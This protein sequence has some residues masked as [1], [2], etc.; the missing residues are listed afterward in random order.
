MKYRIHNTILA[1]IVILATSGCHHQ[2]HG[3]GKVQ[4]IQQMTQ[5]VDSILRDDTCSTN[6]TRLSSVKPTSK[7][8]GPI[9][10]SKRISAKVSDTIVTNNVALI[11]DSGAVKR[12]VE[13]SIVATT[14]EHSGDIP[15]YM[16][17][18]TAD[19]A[20]Y[21]MLPDGQKFD[22]DITIAMRYDSTALPFG[23]TPDD[24]YT[25]FY[26]EQAHMW[27]Q[28]ARDSVDV[29]N[30]IVYSRTNHFTDYINGVLKVPENSDAMAYTP[31]TIKDLKA[32]DPMEGISFIAP[33]EAN[34]QG[35]ANLTYPLAIPAGRHGMQPQLSICYNSA[36]GSGILGMGWSLPIS[37]ISVE[38]R[39]GVPLFDQSYETETYLL[40][41]TTL[42]T[43]YIDDDNYFRLNKPVYHR[44]LENR[45]NADT[46]RFYPRVEGAFRKIERI[47]RTPKSYYWIVTDK[48]G[49]R[50]FYGCT[51][52]SRLRDHKNNI[53]KWML[54]K[55]VDT[56]GN[57]VTYTYVTKTL[58]I[59]SQPLAKQICID[60]IRY[61]GV[62]GG[63]DHGQYIIRF[64]YFD[65]DEKSTS[66]RYGL[67]ETDN[68]VLDRIEVMYRDSIVR[69]Y[70]FG[71]KKG[72]FGKT[73][74]GKIFEGF[75]DEARNQQYI[76][77]DS[78]I[79][80]VPNNPN[81]N[82]K[83]PSTIHDAS[84]YD[85]YYRVCKDSVAYYPIF[86]TFD[87]YGLDGNDLFDEPIVFDATG[88]DGN[89]IDVLGHSLTESGN[90]GVS[91]SYGFNI[92]GS[93]NFGTDYLPW[94]KTISA[95]GHYS[96][97]KDYS[98]GFM[99]L[100]DIDGDGYPDKL[101]RNLTGR[102]KC[103]LQVPGQNRFDTVRYISGVKKFQKTTSSTHNWGIEASAFP[104]IGAGANWSYGMSNTSIYVSD[105]NGDGLID[106]ID[107][108]SVYINKGNLLFEDV[109][110]S[111]VVYIGGTC[112]N[113]TYDV[114]GEV[115]TTI[116]D[117][118]YYTVERTICEQKTD[119]VAVYDTVY[120]ADGTYDVIYD[121]KELRYSRDT[122]WS[123][124]DTFY[125]NYPRRYEP[126]IDLVR[127][128]KAPYSGTVR[129]SGNA[130]L[131][132]TLATFRAMTR[133]NDG[134]RLSIQKASETFFSNPVLL[135]PGMDTSVS[136]TVQVVAGDT[137][138]FRIDAFDKRLYDEVVWNPHIKYT[139]VTLPNNVNVTNFNVV[140]ANGD[141]VYVFDY[142]ADFMLDGIIPVSLGDTT[143]NVCSDTFEVK[144]DLH[145]L[146]PLSQN[147]VYSIIKKSL[148]RNCNE[149]ITHVDTLH[150]G[151]TYS[152]MYTDTIVLTSDS[153][154]FLRLSTLGYG[155]VHW[156]AI[157]A[158]A[159]AR[160]LSSSS[161]M[162][163]SCLNDT[164]M[165]E[166]FIYHPAV[167]REY[168]DYLVFPAIPFSGVSGNPNLSF[169]ITPQGQ[170][171]FSDTLYFTIKDSEN[172][173]CFR[174][175]VLFSN[176]TA[177]ISIDGNDFT[178]NPNKTY[179]VDCY[180]KNTLYDNRIGNITM[181]VHGNVNTMQVGLYAKYSMDNL[182]HH[183]TLYRGWGQFGYKT[184][185]STYCYIKRS[186]TKAAVFYSDSNAV[187][188]PS[189]A[190]IQGFD[191]TAVTAGNPE[192]TVSGNYYNPL[193]GSFFEMNADGAKNRWIGYGNAVSANRNL[194]SLAGDDPDVANG[195][196]AK[197]DMFQSP[198]PVVIPGQKM[199]AVNKMVMTSGFGY[200][201]LQ[202]SSTYGSTSVLGD[203]MDLNGD[204]HPDV[205]S[206]YQI[207]YSK[208]Q[209]GLSEK[210]G[211]YYDDIN[212]TSN[213]TH[214]SSFNGN[215]L[216]AGQESTNNPKKTHV[217][218]K[219][220]GQIPS[221]SVNGSFDN[222]DNTFMDIN[223]DG[224]PDIVYADGTVRYNMGYGFTDS[225]L[226]S[227]PAIRNSQSISSSLSAG[228]NIANTSISGGLSLSQSINET[229]FALMDVNGDGLPDEVRP[230]SIRINLGNGEY[231]MYN[232]LGD[233]DY[234]NSLAISLNFG[235]TY[236]ALFMIGWFPLKFGGGFS[237]GGSAS[238]NHT[239]SEF[240][241]MNNDGFVDYVYQENGQIKVRYS[242]IGKT[243]LLKS[244]T[245]FAKAEMQ[246]D[247]ELSSATVDCPQRQWRMRSL[248]VYDGFDYDGEN[249]NYKRFSYGNRK[250]SRYERDDYGYDTVKTFDY[251]TPTDFNSNNV[252]RT[253]TQVFLN[254][255]YYHNHL[256]ISEKTSK[257]NNYV[258]TIYTYKNA[259]IIGG[260]YI[261]DSLPVWC[262]GAGWPALAVEETR[263]KEGS[264]NVIVTRREYV[265]SDYGNIFTVQDRGDM[266][267]TSDDYS[268]RLSYDL[269]QS[270][271][272]VSNVSRL[273]I[274]GYR[275]RQA[276]YNDRG[277]LERLI[278]DNSPNPTSVYSYDYDNYGNVLSVTT[279]ALGFYS[280][281][282]FSVTYKYDSVLHMLPTNVSNI[283]GHCS[284]TEYSFRWQ[285]PISTCDIGGNY[286]YYT[287]DSHGRTKNILAPKE[288]EYGVPY[289][290]KY[291][292][293]YRRRFNM[294]NIN[295]TFDT[296]NGIPHFFWARTGNFDP[297]NPGNDINT[298]IFSDGL[299]RPIQVKKDVDV[300]GSEMRAVGG[301]VH[302]DGL[303]RKTKEFFL[304]QE[305]DSIASDTTLNCR[306][307]AIQV[308]YT[309]DYLDRVVRSDFADNTFSRNDYSIAPDT[310]GINR[311]LNDVT[312]QNGHTSRVYTDPRQLNIQLKDALGNTTM[313]RYD[314][315]GQ[316][317][318]SIDPENHSTLHEYDHGGRRISRS[319]PSAGVTAWT[320]DPA[321]NM[322]KQ[323]L[324][325]GDSIVYAYDYTRPIRIAHANYPWNDVWYEYGTAGS[326]NQTGRLVKQ[327]DATGV[328]AF[329][330]D[331]M[332][333][334]DTNWHT[335]VMP[336]TQDT[337]SG[338]VSFTQNTFTLRTVWNYDSWGRVKTIVY[339]DMESVEYSYDHGG[340]LFRIE[341]YK[342]G[343]QSTT[344][345]IDTVFYD[346]YEQR[347]YQRDGN[348][349]R[350]HYV[351]DTYN[352]R[353]NKMDNIIP[354]G[355]YLQDN[356]YTYDSVGNI[357]SIIDSGSHYRVQTFQYDHCNRLTHSEGI[358]SDDNTTNYH[359]DYFANYM[360][361]KAGRLEYKDVY[362][363]RRNNYDDYTVQYTNIYN[364]NIPN[365]PYAIECISDYSDVTHHFTWDANGNLL[366]ARHEPTQ[367][368]RRLC[369]NDDNALQGF[370]ESSPNNGEVAAWYNY[371]ANGE[372]NMKFTTAQLR[373]RQNARTRLNQ[374]SLLY[375]TLYASSLIT[376]NKYGY[377][378]HYFDGSSRVCSKIG[379]GF[380]NASWRSINSRIPE[381]SQTYDSLSQRQRDA[382]DST[383]NA[384]FE[385][386]CGLSGS[387]NIYDV[388]YNERRRNDLEYAYYYYN[389][390][391]GSAAYLTDKAGTVTQTLNYL[392]YGEDWIDLRENL[393]PNLG[394]Y[395][396]NGKEKDWESGFHYYGARYYWSEVLTGW[397]SVDP[398]IDK[399]PS[400][401][402]YAYCAWNPIKLIDPDGMEIDDYYNLKGE[403][404][405]HTPEGTNKYLVL[406]N[407]NDVIDDKKLAVPS[408]T[409]I[410]K[411]ERIF[412][413]RSLV[414][415][416]IAVESSGNSSKIITGTENRIS[417]EQWAPALKEIVD[418]GGDVDY[419]VHLH[420][421]R[422]SE[423]KVGSP[424]PSETDRAESNFFNSKLGVIL[425]YEQKIDMNRT[426]TS[427]NEKDYTPTVS[428]YNSSS[429]DA[430][431]K[432]SF[433][434]FKHLVSKI[435]K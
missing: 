404:I 286:M 139:S 176:N 4:A 140:D 374:I 272:I 210:T 105:V 103:R 71:Y 9:I 359:H 166:S 285:K 67:E 7:S 302:Y 208:A 56:Y 217:V 281:N 267:D 202:T 144:L 156:S 232:S 162:L 168:Y 270:R 104:Y 35:T 62:D 20:V 252:Y 69:E 113:E 333:N 377:T 83:V 361:S 78:S 220:T 138:Y 12:D 48:D 356:T 357:V 276:L 119:S 226:L 427:L 40:D 15:D 338:P 59:S 24:I 51:R 425:S 114:S 142:G 199:K 77:P 309:Y 402:P 381:I 405:K 108:G 82:P 416:G 164:N 160:L 256:K 251:E 117:D 419:L 124:F 165:R 234:G 10:G 344:I 434:S 327:Q 68:Y 84:P 58:A 294:V 274:P 44:D 355:T 37:E 118:G 383:F 395:T 38:T 100:V 382:I 313:F 240:T 341:G 257:G 269:N 261:G 387:I 110:D 319:H 87:Y 127:M 109:T 378:K 54:E 155:Q 29:E 46:V 57:T 421:L 150:I 365:N 227:L 248:S 430:I 214:G 389:D 428:F 283:E 76:I 237:L 398:M 429:N 133:T 225:R 218:T 64:K 45:I 412:S 161:A 321:G 433:M 303:G 334:V 293:W 408:K 115:D 198:L 177:S 148:D 353:L 328:Q 233:L 431:Y 305:T 137:I 211:G 393:D 350:T 154:L 14:E 411:M 89:I 91:S 324:N 169:D 244:V 345:Y 407:G 275:L 297:S 236:D 197:V 385:I 409:T 304:R 126:N 129:I 318:E 310:N 19:G 80:N 332:G 266:A 301:K 172:S 316:L 55:S 85:R 207:Q 81:I 229:I 325:S 193:S 397:L 401:S 107:N 70:F 271:Y 184:D 396:F 73:L 288:S 340:N 61:T 418:Q 201:A 362:S 295:S 171:A 330:Y 384:G 298:V 375:P 94:L 287:Y 31:T 400:I 290:V 112:E 299:A 364:Y 424:D 221:L 18:L 213:E 173:T 39:W 216:N 222:T 74:L 183:G 250:Y 432:M 246:L 16:E 26:N 346:R 279:P 32:A 170:Q 311:F 415:K 337:N 264:D 8:A 354:L 135:K 238:L 228:V 93:L 60:K 30:Q 372:R 273:D 3:Q 406:T 296:T 386:T 335:Y 1:V 235:L 219:S 358:W 66:F 5:S 388:L 263:Y 423:Q 242:K 36:G 363:K 145:S 158:Y 72:A 121:G 289:T 435:N 249:T 101:Y 163:D 280:N 260:E 111:K 209:G 147:I 292:Y 179:Y 131:S 34:N 347:I 247:Y 323:T 50:H 128:W 196:T 157:D 134:V 422:L 192:M 245:N 130:K 339:P 212:M 167:D 376:F 373:M 230:N 152:H 420:P 343:I 329:H 159:T 189:N 312:D 194:C 92:G 195:D 75:D 185:D 392:P 370:F 21:R 380:G 146:V 326:G 368:E 268:V 191:T 95:G 331:C 399:Y 206:E 180:T 33:P 90:I 182:K 239:G 174:R 141:S 348:G 6:V 306:H 243:N 203:Y 367:T 42:V 426:G 215:F 300:Q 277:S 22:K 351:Y 116:F 181:Q 175:E 178:F 314:P 265:Y 413:S 258:E 65:K 282:L 120:N 13:I 190:N 28:V 2:E 23:F 11:I 231:T 99:M 132:D 43:S 253:T 125:Y 307:A 278:I 86:H 366:S 291:D 151:D 79:Y 188:H 25:F 53:A 149:S 315:V 200:T 308:Q 98:D 63:N 284:R 262:Y 205:V 106:V 255:N 52:Q 102:L 123:V 186:L 371:N 41:G 352:R 410:D 224:L 403:L 241:D 349:V 223:G 136:A 379:G 360:Y 47:G 342:P 254:D 27:Q 336:N 390:H 122:C 88:G 391:L 322:I 143:N 17:N 49:T 320:Y 153:C 317:I 259:E 187:P 96:F 204:R 369:W 97:N 394:Q 417:S 414:E